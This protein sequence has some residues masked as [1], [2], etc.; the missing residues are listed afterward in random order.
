MPRYA[1]TGVQAMAILRDRYAQVNAGTGMGLGSG[2]AL[3]TGRCC[4]RIDAGRTGRVLDF[5]VPFPRCSPLMLRYN[6]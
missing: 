6:L 3:S 1:K 4:K 2:G 5:C